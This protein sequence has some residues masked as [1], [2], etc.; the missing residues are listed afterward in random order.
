MTSSPAPA[1]I[2]GPIGP[3]PPPLR[4]RSDSAWLCGIFGGERDHVPPWTALDRSCQVLL[5]RDCRAWHRASLAALW[6]LSARW[7]WR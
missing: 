1:F 4:S 7:S 5:S 6:Y 3:P 2:E